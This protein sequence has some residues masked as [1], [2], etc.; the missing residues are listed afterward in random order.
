MTLEELWDLNPENHEATNAAHEFNESRPEL[1]GELADKK[2]EANPGDL[3]DAI[4]IGH[5]EHARRLLENGANPNEID[6]GLNATPLMPAA[7]AGD[8][9]MCKTLISAGA[10]VRAIQRGYKPLMYAAVRNHVSVVDLLLTAGA[11][12]NV[13]GGFRQTAFTM[14]FRGNFY[15]C[16]RLMVI[17]GADPSGLALE[18]NWFLDTVLA[19]QRT[20]LLARIEEAPEERLDRF[21]RL[22]DEYAAAVLARQIQSQAHGE[23]GV[24][25]P[26]RKRE[27]VVF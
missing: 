17:H 11:D 1:F 23:P 19:A 26:S 8:V 16:A 14:A 12:L 27:Q 21:A 4:R 6:S 7:G 24:A 15:E 18:E 22:G 9:A 2:E 5:F 20:D 13:E 3:C 10:S 25:I